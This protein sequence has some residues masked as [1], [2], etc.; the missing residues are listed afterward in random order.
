MAVGPRFA[1]NPQ[2]FINEIR[3][4]PGD[5]ANSGKPIVGDV[6]VRTGRPVSPWTSLAFQKLVTYHED[7][8]SYYFLSNQ[9]FIK[10]GW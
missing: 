7:H 2:D 3:S 9:D 8:F 6:Y 5:I 4:N 10:D 1:C